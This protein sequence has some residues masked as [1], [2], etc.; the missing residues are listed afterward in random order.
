[1]PYR[2][3]SPAVVVAPVHVNGYNISRSMGRKGMYVVAVDSKPDAVGFLSRYVK[4][5]KISFW[6]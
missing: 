1:M 4:E 3:R 5:S 6:F 2:R